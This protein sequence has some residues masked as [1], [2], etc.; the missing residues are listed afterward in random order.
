LICTVH[1]EILFDSSAISHSSEKRLQDATDY[2][3]LDSAPRCVK[4]DEREFELAME[5]ANRC[6]RILLG[7]ASPW[8]SPARHTLYREAALNGGYS[9]GLTK[10]PPLIEQ[11]KVGGRLVMPVGPAYT[12]Q[13]LTVVEKIASDKTTTRAVALVRFVP[14]TRSQN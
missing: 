6:E 5:I 7:H 10:P 13:H 12:T 9:F 8:T 1:N 14:F 4:L 2:I 3:D 11:L